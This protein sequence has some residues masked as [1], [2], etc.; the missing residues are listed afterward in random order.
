MSECQEEHKM[1]WDT[2]FKKSRSLVLSVVH[3][4]ISISISVSVWIDYVSICIIVT[5]LIYV[6]RTHWYSNPPMP[7]WHRVRWKITFQ[8]HNINLQIF[9]GEVSKGDEIIQFH[10]LQ[11]RPVSLWGC[12][13]AKSFLVPLSPVLT[14]CG[15]PTAGWVSPVVAFHLKSSHLHMWRR[16]TAVWPLK[17][18]ANSGAVHYPHWGEDTSR[19]STWSPPDSGL[20][21]LQLINSYLASYAVSDVSYLPDYSTRASKAG[22]TFNKQNNL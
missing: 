3:T 20:T 6:G 21:A 10:I 22:S 15:A 2:L 4:S 13:P 7:W 14:G 1:K 19:S 5:I 9:Q 18:T 12:M 17:D 16:S 11:L 8:R